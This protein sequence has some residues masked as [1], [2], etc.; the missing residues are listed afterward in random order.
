MKK[1]IK[2]FIKNV[3]NI[4][5]KKSKKTKI[6]KEKIKIKIKIIWDICQA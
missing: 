1:R 3:T 6:K 4:S 2:K 5:K